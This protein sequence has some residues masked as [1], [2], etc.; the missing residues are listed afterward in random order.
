MNETMSPTVLSCGATEHIFHYGPL[1]TVVPT[2]IHHTKCDNNGNCSTDS[3]AVMKS[4][5]S[6]E[7]FVST[8]EPRNLFHNVTNK[9][10]NI[11]HNTINSGKSAHFLSGVSKPVFYSG[12]VQ[13]ATNIFRFLCLSSKRVSLLQIFGEL[14][15][16]WTQ[17]HMQIVKL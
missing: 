3:F 17:K 14:F 7:T 15:S 13:L 8:S 5:T 6:K 9:S 2:V 12:N 1:S 11:K 10:R 4:D 16:R